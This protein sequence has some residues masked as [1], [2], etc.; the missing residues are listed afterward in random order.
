MAFKNRE[1]NTGNNLHENQLIISSSVKSEGG[2]M[3]PFLIPAREYSLSLGSQEQL[4]ELSQQKFKLE[5][6][7][8]GILSHLDRQG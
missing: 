6:A 4:A 2:K 5:C 7:M 8:D 1:K 3:S